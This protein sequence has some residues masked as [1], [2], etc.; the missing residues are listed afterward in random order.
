MPFGPPAGSYGMPMSGSNLSVFRFSEADRVVFGGLA[1]NLQVV[2]VLWILFGLLGTLLT[3]P[4]VVLQGVRGLSGL[5]G[6][7][8]ALVQGITL[9]AAREHLRRVA[10]GAGDDL[11]SAME[12]VAG[13]RPYYTVMLVVTLL[14]VAATLLALVV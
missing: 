10:T 14:Q 7:V 5:L 1:A 3:A 13:L 9:R 12:G 8:G 6:C 4:N 11:S 2:S